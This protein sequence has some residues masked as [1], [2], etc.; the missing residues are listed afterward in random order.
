MWSIRAYHE[1]SMH[2]F[3]SFLTLTYDDDHLPSDNKINKPDLQKFFKR[4]RKHFKFKYLACGE[5]GELTRRPHYHAIIFG[6]HF[7]HGGLTQMIDDQQ[8]TNSVVEKIW[9]QGHISIAECNL[10]T[11]MYTCGY[12]HKKIGDDETFRLMSRGS[13]KVSDPPIWRYGIGKAWLEKYKDDLIKTAGHPVVT[14]E[15]REF[16][17]PPRYIDWFEDDFAEVKKYRQEHA[18]KKALTHGAL[19]MRNKEKNKRAQ[20]KQRKSGEI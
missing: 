20:L 9:G 13:G 12:V 11:I 3:N 4:M 15:G 16:P 6:E 14:M 17:I 19:S 2:K 5:Y 8:Y 7:N 1:A 10:S 18:K